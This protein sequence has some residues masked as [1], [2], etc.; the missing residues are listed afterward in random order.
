MN[1]VTLFKG[2]VNE[3]SYN[4]GEDLLLVEFDK[5]GEDIF[6]TLDLCGIT[7]EFVKSNGIL[8]LIEACIIDGGYCYLDVNN[9]NTP[10]I[11]EAVELHIQEN[12]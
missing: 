6:I 11:K 4:L 9:F 12:I 3:S 2:T 1:E 7:L 10:D 5:F 8:E